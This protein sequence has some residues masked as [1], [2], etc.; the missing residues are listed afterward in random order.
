MRVRRGRHGYNQARRASG[1]L[2]GPP[3]GESSMVVLI[4]KSVFLTIMV[5]V[6]MTIIIRKIV[7]WLGRQ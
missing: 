6:A 1:G 2:A 5:S 7:R 3:A 4:F